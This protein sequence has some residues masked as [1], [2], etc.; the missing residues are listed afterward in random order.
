[1]RRLIPALCVLPLLLACEEPLIDPP[2]DTPDPLSECDGDAGHAFDVGGFD[3]S[4]DVA[5]I[6]GDTLFVTVGYGG[7]CETH[8]WSLCWPDQSFMESEPVQ[9]SLE[10][11][12]GGPADMCEA[13]L[14]EELE[15]DL[16]PL[17]QA[18]KDSYGDGP[19]VILVGVAG[20][21]LEYS[22]E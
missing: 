22:F 21:S 8:E 3:T 10:I 20:E 6:D 16:G 9:V 15:F 7:G 1:M 17:K 18:W 2:I 5:S 14:T 12:H 4:G 11:F 13:Y 19:G